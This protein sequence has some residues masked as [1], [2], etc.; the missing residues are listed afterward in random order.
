MVRRFLSILMSLLFFTILGCSNT[1]KIVPEDTSEVRI[2]ISWTEDIK[3]N[4]IPEDTQV[5]IDAVKKAGAVPILLPQ[6][7]NKVKAYEALAT[8]DAVIMTG[9]EDINPGFYH[10]KPN[11]KL[12]TVNNP[13]DLSDYILLATALK[14]DYPILATCRGMQFLNVIKGG[15]LFQDLPTQ[16]PTN[17]LHRDPERKV[18]TKHDSIITD[19]DSHLYE[20]LQVKN[21]T[22]N[23]W[24]HQAVKDLGKDLKVVSIAPDGIIEAIEVPSATFV[25]A[26]Q[27]HPE[28]CVADNEDKFIDFFKVLKEYGRKHKNMK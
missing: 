7:K 19:T 5:Y 22:V 27:Y 23:S 13:R 24:H 17:I 9:G 18:F 11:P 21:I 3:D 6:I 4:A 20:I 8:I 1:Q 26:V 10:E 12:E 28:W 25:V 16:K 14:E 15:T 2:G